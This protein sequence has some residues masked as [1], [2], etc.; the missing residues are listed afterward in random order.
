MSSSPAEARPLVSVGLPVYNGERY[1]GEA[2]EAVLSQT[3]RDFELV[4]SDNASTDRTGEIC[5]H[6]AGDDPRV[7]YHRNPENLGAAPNFNRCYALASPSA[8][9]KWMTYDDLITKDFLDRCLEALETDTDVSLAFPAVVHADGDGKVT[10]RQLKSD[11]SLIDNKPARRAQL[12]IEYGLE[13]PDIY[14]SLYGVM[15]RSALE[16]TQL[17]GSYVASDQVLLFELAIAG[18]FVQ[19][20]EALLIHRAHPNAWTAMTGRTPRGDATWFGG[21]SARVVLPHWALLGHHVG[22]ILRADL[23]F[24]EKARCT[25]AVAHRALREW[26]NLGGDLKLAIRDALRPRRLRRFDDRSSQ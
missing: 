19:V 26:R 5:G 13:S 10:G 18:K 11:L 14:W 9:F 20:P 8:Y 4:I 2:I 15:R 12:L 6:F 3:F 16:K 23:T 1:V 17:H 7:R 21:S 22:S 25:R 24:R